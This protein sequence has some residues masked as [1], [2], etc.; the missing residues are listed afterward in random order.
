[1]KR[2]VLGLAMVAVLVGCSNQTTRDLEGVPAK[3]PDKAEVYINVDE[4]PNVARECIDG[5][6]FAFTTKDYLPLMRV[7]EWDDWCAE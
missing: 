5:V 1:M 4:F 7:P 6:A 2:L 3:E